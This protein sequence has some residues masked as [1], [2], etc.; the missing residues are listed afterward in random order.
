MIN[1]KY[2]CFKHCLKRIIKTYNCL[3]MINKNL[4]SNYKS[5]DS[6]FKPKYS[7]LISLSCLI[8][9]SPSF[10]FSVFL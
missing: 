9:I 8:D 2:N 1:N 3:D 6:F 5:I 10:F 7:I 4:F